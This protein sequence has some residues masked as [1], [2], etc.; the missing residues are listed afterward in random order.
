M[1]VGVA[2]GTDRTARWRERLRRFEGRS[3]TVEAFCKAEAVSAWSLYQWRRKLGTKGGKTVRRGRS[4]FVELGTA[5]VSGA[6]AAAAPLVSSMVPGVELRIDLG[7][8]LVL[9]IV[10]R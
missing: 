9:Q 10:R 1:K 8:G 6:A 2:G 5:G 4:G 7:G 3:G